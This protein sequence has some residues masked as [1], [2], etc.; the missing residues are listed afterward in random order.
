M[1]KNKKKKSCKCETKDCFNCQRYEHGTRELLSAH[2]CMRNGYVEPAKIK[3]CKDFLKKKSVNY[4]FGPVFKQE[5]YSNVGLN[6]EY[7]YKD[8]YYGGW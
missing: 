1:K 6:D 4:W 5:F 3:N 2:F 8:D 7:N